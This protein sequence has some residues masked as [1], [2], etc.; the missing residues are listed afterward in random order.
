[1]VVAS[2]DFFYNIYYNLSHGESVARIDRL[3]FS[4]PKIG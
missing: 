4:F 1:M 2:R 3:P